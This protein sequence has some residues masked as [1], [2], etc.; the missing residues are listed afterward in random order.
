MGE[1]I[2]NFRDRLKILAEI[3]DLIESDEIFKDEEVQIRVNLE[4]EKYNSILKNFREI[5]WGSN[6]FFINIGNVSFK[7]VLKK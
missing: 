1:N 2:K 7:F 3:S 5:D 4:T 6:K